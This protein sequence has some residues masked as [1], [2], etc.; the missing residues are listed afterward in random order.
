MLGILVAE[1][2]LGIAEKCFEEPKS[3]QQRRKTTWQSSNV[4]IIRVLY[5]WATV[6]SFGIETTLIIATTTYCAL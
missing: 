5:L 1:K 6:V 3:A 4:H 2:S